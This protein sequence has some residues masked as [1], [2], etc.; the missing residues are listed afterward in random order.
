MNWR[1]WSFIAAAVVALVPAARAQDYPSRSVTLVVPY[2]AGGSTTLV[3]RM[4]GRQLEQRLG[5]PVVIENRPGAGTLIG[6][7]SVAR[8]EPDGYTILFATSTTMAINVTLYKK[9]TYDPVRDF[10]PLALVADNPFILVVNPALPIHS[11]ADLVKVAKEKPGE[12]TFASSGSG[13]AAHLFMELVQSLT[14]TKMTHVPYRGLSPGLNDVV[15]G[16]VSLMFGDFATSL[17]LIRAGKL[18]ALGVST[19]QRNGA[20]PDLPTVAEAGLAGYEASAWHMIVAPAKTPRPIVDRLNAELKA[21]AGDPELNKQLI[22]QGITPLVTKPPEE[23]ARFVSSEIARWGKVVE[24][25]G[26]AASE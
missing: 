2:V 5:K 8:A 12:L 6:A 10:V 16:H 13:S 18:R 3:A 17:P 11:I 9:L 24:R 26:V 21:A 22:E 23:L 20:A 4:F 14:D 19:G 15:A 25:A 7:S 1:V